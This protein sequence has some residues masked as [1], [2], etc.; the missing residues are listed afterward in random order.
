MSAL[1]SSKSFHEFMDGDSCKCSSLCT[2]AGHLQP[3]G[4]NCRGTTNVNGNSSGFVREAV[5][6]F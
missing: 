6:T 4:N 2:E 1:I 3:V 5:L